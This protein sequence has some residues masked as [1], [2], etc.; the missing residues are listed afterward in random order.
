MYLS[1]EQL[2]RYQA[3][4]RKTAGAELYRLTGESVYAQTA[5]RLLD[6]YV[7]TQSPSGSWVHTL[8]Y[9]SAEEQTFCWTADITWEYGA[10]FSDVLYDLCAR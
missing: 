2:Q 3:C 8:W 7:K 1:Q 5:C 6:Q 9:K 10:E 4:I